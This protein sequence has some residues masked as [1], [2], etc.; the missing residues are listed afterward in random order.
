MKLLQIA[1]VAMATMASPGFAG[2]PADTPSQIKIVAMGEVNDAPEIA[3][4]SFTIRGEGVSAD[5]A[6]RALVAKRVAI[7]AGLAPFR[8]GDSDLKTSGLSIK[9]ARSGDCDTND[10]D[11]T[12]LSEGPCAIKGYVA[13]LTIA[14]RTA[15]I[16]D[17][18]TIL[19][20]A[21]RLGA[22]DA[23]LEGYALRD[24]A[25][26]RKRALA[27]AVADGKAQGEAIAMA[28]GGRLGRLV[29]I[30]DETTATSAEEIVVTA[31]LNRPA[32][33][34]MTAVRIELSP[35]PV[36]NTATLIMT[37]EMAR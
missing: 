22:S 17:A 9:P 12:T 3:K 11:K 7:D 32:P 1:I 20:V 24:E 26:A 4:L 21:S 31:Q 18:G 16:A 25:A 8:G 28:A 35:A 29:Q 2:S 30:Q 27:A 23:E 19:G 15:A 10:G 36:R 34:V 13:E 14:Y 6:T 33:E 37:F 5:A